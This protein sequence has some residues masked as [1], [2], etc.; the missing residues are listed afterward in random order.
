M[1]N[2]Q[3]IHHF[4]LILYQHKSLFKS[5]Y[6]HFEFLKYCQICTNNFPL[7]MY[8]IIVILILVRN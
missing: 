4:P 7:N 1:S 6:I 8:K 5:C 3:R 2:L